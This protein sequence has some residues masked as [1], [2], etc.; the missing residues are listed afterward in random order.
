MALVSVTPP[1][2]GKS[3]RIRSRPRDGRRWRTRESLHKL[4][5]TEAGQGCGQDCAPRPFPA[6]LGGHGATRPARPQPSGPRRASPA[7]LLAAPR[8]GR[9]RPRAPRSRSPPALPLGSW[10]GSRPLTAQSSRSRPGAPAATGAGAAA[11]GSPAQPAKRSLP[12]GA[13]NGVLSSRPLASPAVLHPSL[14]PPLQ[15]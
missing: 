9:R 3:H 12:A 1:K 2:E 13:P 11:S 4:R 15:S 8:P 6:A 14:P 10:P 7:G 5:S